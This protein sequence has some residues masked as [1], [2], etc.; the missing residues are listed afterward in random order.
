MNRI[1]TITNTR[2]KWWSII[3]VNNVTRFGKKNPG[4]CD[5]WETAEIQISIDVKLIETGFGVL[6]ACPVLLLHYT[7]AWIIKKYP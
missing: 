5:Q 7:G 6:H 4:A 3:H 2:D 1:F